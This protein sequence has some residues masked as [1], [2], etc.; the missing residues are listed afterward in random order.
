MG[1]SIKDTDPVPVILMDI[2]GEDRVC[3][4]VCDKVN[5]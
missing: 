2:G 4:S 1:Q 3:V 5:G